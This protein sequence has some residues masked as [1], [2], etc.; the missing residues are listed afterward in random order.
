MITLKNT[1]EDAHFLI[2]KT[3]APTVSRLVIKNLITD[4]E[5]EL[6]F[7]SLELANSYRLS[8]IDPDLSGFQGSNL[9]LVYDGN[10]QLIY[11][12]MIFYYTL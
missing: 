9:L 6:G 1:Q 2:Y 11:K 12:E 7:E 8:L 5:Q 4:Q 3:H 10:D